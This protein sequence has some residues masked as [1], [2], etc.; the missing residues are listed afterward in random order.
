MEPTIVLR[1]GRRI[2]HRSTS[3][4][5]IGVRPVAAPHPPDRYVALGQSPDD[6]I[7]L[8]GEAR[9]GGQPNIAAQIHVQV[10]LHF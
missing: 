8:A 10:P 5:T 9:R 6:L 4:T 3:R 2:G 1:R 7:D